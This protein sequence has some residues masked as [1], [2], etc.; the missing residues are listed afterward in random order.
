MRLQKK[1]VDTIKNAV[2]RYECGLPHNFI[3]K[4][5]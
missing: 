4:R 3:L 2:C 1:S 5:F